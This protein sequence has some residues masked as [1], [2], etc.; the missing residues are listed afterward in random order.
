MKIKGAMWGMNFLVAAGFIA[1]FFFGFFM[2]MNYLGPGDINK[3][4]ATV[5]EIQSGSQL[6]NF[7][8]V[9]VNAHVLADLPV[10]CSDLEHVLDSF[11]DKQIG[12]S[13][14]VNNK[15]ECSRGDL[16]ESSVKLKLF[17]PGYKDN[18]NNVVL[19]VSP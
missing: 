6:L 17:L 16:K 5:S 10:D 18:V 19:E 9:P 2:L 12:Y 14:V 13:F 7:F 8:R 11:Y 15:E 1:L 4:R 3:V